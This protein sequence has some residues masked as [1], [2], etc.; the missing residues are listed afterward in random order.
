MNMQAPSVRGRTGR[1]TRSL[2]LPWRFPVD[3]HHR[4]RVTGLNRLPE[5]STWLGTQGNVLPAW[6]S[7][8]RVSHTSPDADGSLR[9]PKRIP[10][11]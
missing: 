2:Q 1:C 5:G 8:M 10:L 11:G 7:Q 4:D 3:Y 9:D 6:N